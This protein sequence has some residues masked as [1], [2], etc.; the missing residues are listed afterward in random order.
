LLQGL[1]YEKK[2]KNFSA[3]PLWEWAFEVADDP[4]ILEL[5]DDEEDGMKKKFY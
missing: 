3:A 1:L 5:L 2:D 4:L